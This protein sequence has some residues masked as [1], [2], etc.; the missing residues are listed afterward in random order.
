MLEKRGKG[1][2]RIPLR[3][4]GITNAVFGRD[5]GAAHG[6]DGRLTAAVLNI[7]AHKNRVGIRIHQTA[8]GLHVDG[9]ERPLGVF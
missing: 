2:N 4:Q 3:C 8:G 1:E 6:F 5:I 7:P 9:I